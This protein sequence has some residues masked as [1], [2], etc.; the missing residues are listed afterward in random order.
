M[1]PPTPRLLTRGNPG[2]VGGVTPFQGRTRMREDV[3][4]PPASWS[5]PHAPS[6][7]AR[8]GQTHSLDRDEGLVSPHNGRGSLREWL[9]HVLD[10]PGLICTEQRGAGLCSC[11]QS[12]VSPR[13]GLLKHAGTSHHC[14]R[15][16]ETS[17][18]CHLSGLHRAPDRALTSSRLVQISCRDKNAGDGGS[19]GHISAEIMRIGDG[20]PS[21][22]HGAPF[23]KP[24]SC[25]R[26]SSSGPFS[27]FVPSELPL[28]RRGTE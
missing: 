11:R 7:G 21:P 12:A 5:A 4:L 17:V 16:A 14:R 18:P 25:P 20:P 13:T 24:S 26:L 9:I 28:I 8:A 27:P 15:H 23:S 2:Q 3:H 10:R 22:P 1:S 19:G 6:H